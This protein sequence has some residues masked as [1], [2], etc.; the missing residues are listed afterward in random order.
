MWC[1]ITSLN[2]TFQKPKSWSCHCSKRAPAFVSSDLIIGIPTLPVTQAWNLWVTLNPSHFY[3]PTSRCLINPVGSTFEISLK[4]RLF[5]TL[6]PILLLLEFGSFVSFAFTI[7]VLT[8]IKVD[9]FEV[10]FH[11]FNTPQAWV[12]SRSL[13]AQKLSIACPHQPFNPYM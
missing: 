13:F 7:A 6:S 4:S 8:L 1:S 3:T 12:L 11:L 5:S 2:S 9:L 10:L